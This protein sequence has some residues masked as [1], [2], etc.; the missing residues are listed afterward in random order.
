MDTRRFFQG[1]EYRAYRMLGSH[2][3]TRDGRRGYRFAVW[4]PNALAV[5][6]VGDFNR[7]N[8]TAH[9]MAREGGIWRLFIPGVG[10]YAMYKYAITTQTGEVLYKGDPYAFHWETRPGTASK[11]LDLMG[12]RW[13]DEQ[14]MRRRDCRAP[15]NV[16]E[17][18]LGSWRRNEAGGFLSY[19]KLADELVPY[20]KQMGYT[21]L[22]LLPVM[23]HPLD[24]SWGYQITGY[25][26]PT[27]RYGIPMDFMYFV[28]E[29]HR[30]G[31][32][33]ILDWVPAHFPRDAQ[34]LRRFDGTALYEHPDP[35]RGEHPQWGT[36]AFD[37]AKPEVRSFL[38]SNV[39]YWLDLYHV[40]GFRVDA[41]SSMLY[42][43]FGR[44]PGQ[45]L[46]NDRGGRENLE[47]IS[48]LRQL[49]TVVR[50]EFPGVRMIAEEST[51]WP[52][53]TGPVEE[54]GL[55]FT[56]KWNMGWMNDMLAYMSADP[57]D[58]KYRHDK[59]T[60][61]MCYAFS[62]RFVLPLSH[63]EVVHGK[64][65]LLDRMP[66]EY[67]GKFAQLRALYGF[68]YAH[69][70]GKLLFMGGEFAQFIEWNDNQGLDW[71][72]LDYDRH[73]QM[74]RYVRYLNR[75]YRGQ[76]P[77]WDQDGSWD[78]FRWLV[79]DDRD[80][81]VAAFLRRDRAGRELIAVVNF[82]PVPRPHYRIGLPGPGRLLE[83]FNSDLAEFGGS[84]CY[85]DGPL[86]AEEIPSHG[87][88]WSVALSV[89]PFGACYYSYDR[90]DGKERGKDD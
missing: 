10:V 22:E 46:P 45:W 3:E 40:D 26:A 27:S 20:V 43:D 36:C 87:Q 35:R 64:R 47:A 69:P 32:G 74:Q 37:F 85:Q 84:D 11:A 77:L 81:S 13:G 56:H 76:R 63:D 61:S 19:R 29:C 17:V 28:D 8:P 30:Q 60:F 67:D 79:V 39:V 83:I 57:L 88:R 31:L 12:Y 41:V 15:M 7:G 48:F 54:G 90:T 50:R 78:G 62:E 86:D 34:G 82:T 33:V 65:S 2:P 68:M 66:G 9:P 71:L 73:R 59:L 24:G 53:V 38:I 25:Y 55:G 1:R 5:S 52:Q 75:F 58:R 16:Y 23:E 49:N 51:A 89:P 18:H 42:L 6:V 14:W 80:N 72:L 70:G 4:A 21:H 44:E